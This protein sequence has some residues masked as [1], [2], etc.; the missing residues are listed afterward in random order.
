M[1][2]TEVSSL[3]AHNTLEFIFLDI[4]GP[5]PVTKSGNKYLVVFG[6]RYSKAM[7]V[8]AVPNITTETLAR[9]FVL[10]WVAVYGIPYFLLT[11]NGTQFISKLFQTVCRLLG[12]DQLF[13]TAYHPSTNGQGERFNQTV[14][15]SVT[16]FVSEHQDNWDE[17]AGVATYADNTTIQ[18]T[19]GF[20]PFEL[21]LS[22][23]PS[24]GIL[25]PD[26]AFGGDP[27]LSSKAVFRQNF[28]HRVEKLGNAVGETVPIRQQRYKDNYDR[29][30][31]RRNTQIEYGDLVYVKTFVT[32]PGRSPKLEFPAAGHF[33]VISN[34]VNSFLLRT[35]SRDQRVSSD[36]VIKAG[37]SSD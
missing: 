11:E 15:K 5:L 17:I 19:T 36:R 35:R 20:A 31:Q 4:I 28:L 32:K 8:V 30:V 1:N 29:N 14:L 22:R 10:D 26:I 34:D 9:A 12:V 24:P 33:V 21:I 3:A 37:V 23:A 25:Q 13:T 6:D 27:P 16:H 18:S 7:S 2:S